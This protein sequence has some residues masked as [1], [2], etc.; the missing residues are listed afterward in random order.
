MPL[1]ILNPSEP[2]L[3]NVLLRWWALALVIMCDAALLSR[4][5]VGVIY[6]FGEI[7]VSKSARIFYY[8]NEL[9][10]PFALLGWGAG[11]LI[12]LNVWLSA[13]EPNVFRAFHIIFIMIIVRKFTPRTPRTPKN[14]KTKRRQ[15]FFFSLPPSLRL[16]H[17][18]ELCKLCWLNWSLVYLTRRN[19]GL[20]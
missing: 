10:W 8:I 18:D 14:P 19:F 20:K 1:L 13:L 15:F 17:A 6:F 5:A 11:M 12:T 4:L 2:L 9:E 16:L 3:A 7:I